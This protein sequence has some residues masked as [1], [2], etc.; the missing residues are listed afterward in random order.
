MSKLNLIAAMAL[1]VCGVAHSQTQAKPLPL[2]QPL[3]VYRA[4][5]NVLADQ[6]NNSAR[7][8]AKSGKALEGTAATVITV[9][10]NS[11]SSLNL[12][13]TPGTQNL[14]GV[15][16]VNVLDGKLESSVNHMQLM[17]LAS[18][19]AFDRPKATGVG[20]AI[21]KLCSQAFEKSDTPFK[22]T[23]QGVEM[24]CMVGLGAMVVAVGR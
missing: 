12:A 2:N 24:A 3:E 15:T 7:L 11:A 5:F 10:L 6:M 9:V 21:T 13:L 16:L 14:Q 20:D 23:V 1:A 17:L 18:M 22:R 4:R 8:D 19:A